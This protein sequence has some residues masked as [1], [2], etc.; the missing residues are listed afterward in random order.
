MHLVIEMFKDVFSA[1][2]PAPLFALLPF[3]TP[4]GDTEISVFTK[5]KK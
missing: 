3:G 4:N 2:E 5:R 1:G